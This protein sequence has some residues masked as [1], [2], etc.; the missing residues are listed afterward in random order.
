MLKRLR[1]STLVKGSLLIF[2]ANN[3]VN[4]GNFLYNL[5]M[6]RF[7][8]PE[9]YGELG[10]VLSILILV[11]VPLGILSLLITKIVSG[12]WGKRDLSQIYALYALLVPKLLLTGSAVGILLIVIQPFIAE[13][14]HLESNL[15]ILLIAGYL[16]FSFV[17][18][19]NRSVLHGAL[20]F[21]LITVNS[22]VEI[23]TKLIIAVSLVLLNFGVTG[24]LSGV[25]S[26]AAVSLIFTMIELRVLFRKVIKSEVKKME[27]SMLINSFIPVLFVSLSLTSFFTID[28]IL[29][30]HFFSSFTAGEYTALSTVG[31]ISYYAAGPAIAVMFPLISGRAARGVT[32]ILP[33]LGTLVFVLLVSSGLVFINFLFPRAV[34]S[35]LYGAKYSSLSS[36]LGIYSFFITIYAVNSVLTY[37]LL[38]VSFYKPLILLFLISM[39][40]GIAILFFHN[41]ISDVIWVNI[42]TGLIYFATVLIFTVK[43]EYIVIGR[44]LRKVN[45]QGVYG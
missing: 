28:V 9:K 45:P 24:A 38:S 19:L 36:L 4:F 5:F 12:F 10:A 8:G 3:A 2:I 31:R 23:L 25:L 1:G 18:T 16:T 26:G 11:G 21:P 33:L 44:I 37:F 35:L 20:K 7:L 13:F 6:G 30:R 42:I 17:A 29:V 34:M 43:K 32:Y 14:L 39:S 15:P 40:Q 22:L 27:I 41:S